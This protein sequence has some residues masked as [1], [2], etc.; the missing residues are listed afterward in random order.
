MARLGGLRAIDGGAGRKKRKQTARVKRKNNKT[1]GRGGFR[2]GRSRWRRR[3]NEGT[4]RRGGWDLRFS[5]LFSSRGVYEPPLIEV[6]MGTVRWGWEGKAG[7]EAFG[8][9]ISGFPGQVRVMDDI[10]PGGEGRGTR[11]RGG[12]GGVGGGP[13]D[14]EAGTTRYGDGDGDGDGRRRRGRHHRLAGNGRKV[15]KGIPRKRF[16]H[17]ERTQAREETR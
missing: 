9:R 15:A 4:V 13:E 1:K 11:A 14:D 3:E 2:S 6:A 10:I 17:G 12:V 7:W 5:R 8:W 16:A